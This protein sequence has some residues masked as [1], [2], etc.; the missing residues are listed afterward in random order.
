MKLLRKLQ[1]P[2]FEKTAARYLLSDNPSTWPSELI[3]HLYK[4]HPFLGQYQV[5]LS[6]QGQDQS[7]GYM[8]GVFLVSQPTD[9]PPADP[10][11]QMGQAISQGQ[12]PAPPE[13]TV[14][15][16][17]I[18]ESKRTFSY[19][20]FITPDG[21]FLPL[22]EPR[23]AGAM[24]NAS[25]FAAAPMPKPGMGMTGA[26]S[27]NMDPAMPQ[28][29]LGG[30]RT[31]PGASSLKTASVVEGIVTEEQ[32]NQFLHKLAESRS[33]VDAVELNSAFKDAISKIAAA[34]K[35]D[36]ESVEE[37][38]ATGYDAMLISK[39]PGGYL[40]KSASADRF[41]VVEHQLTNKEGEAL[42]R[43]IRQAIFKTGSA[44]LVN[45]E[46]PGLVSPE[47]TKG[48]KVVE[49]SGIYAIMSKTGS[50]QRAAIITGLTSLD[51][52]ETSLNLI[53][54]KSGASVQ[55]KV[56]GVRCGNLDLASVSGSEPMGEGVF[57][58]KTAGKVSEPVTIL[59]RVDAEGESSYM[60]EHPLRGRGHI[61]KAAV[62]GIV[63]T[64]TDVLIPNDSVFIPITYGKKYA[65]DEYRMDKIASRGDLM[66]KVS[67]VSDGSEVTFSGRPI[68]SFMKKSATTTS[69][70][71][72]LL[73]L[74]AFGDTPE[75]AKE[76]LA[77]AGQGSTVVFT[78]H[79]AVS[80]GT[81]AETAVDEEVE[82]IANVI[83]V[84]LTKEAASLKS[85]D[86]VDSV[87]SLNFITPENIS[88]Y[89]NALPSFEEASSSLAELLIG[90]RLGLSDVPEAAVS[91]ALGGMERAI[92]GLKKLQ[93]RS[94]APM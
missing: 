93:I 35:K 66:N 40:L 12:P 81:S 86:T 27:Q 51:G 24:F 90:V 8:Y 11:M 21:K 2:V 1:A 6:I 34:S 25:P 39:S 67:I 38:Q 91:S 41:H 43:E 45:P 62:K 20:V 85:T 56:A 30:G 19:D 16:P 71:D 31:G 83:R 36:E 63:S 22:N 7:M 59:H 50:S 55:E 94:N 92:Q 3:A 52:R 15:I 78:P 5:N 4:Q 72:A 79:R 75:G 65:S 88:G 60:Y 26:A 14:R 57:L 73:I 29:S 77:A 53:V 82:K 64:G 76:K 87:L 47:D 89:L 58:L 68:A 33:L 69:F 46:N 44:L 74:G 84:D 37:D 80:R 54:G 10:Q 17:I 18:V 42:P 23:L 9:V 70:D 61:K 28:S 32:V 48:L 13:M 49:D